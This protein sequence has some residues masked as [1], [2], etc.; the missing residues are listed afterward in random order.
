MSVLFF[1]T[2]LQLL[3]IPLLKKLNGNLKSSSEW[4]TNRS[5]LMVQN[6]GARGG[7]GSGGGTALGMG[8]AG[9]GH[10]MGALGVLAAAS[11][12]NNS[13][14]TE[15]L[16]FGR[17]RPLSHDAKRRKR[18]EDKQRGAWDEVAI[19]WADSYQNI[20]QFHNAGVRAF[21]DRDHFAA[22][23][24]EIVGHRN[25]NSVIGRGGRN[26]ARGAAAVIEGVI[27]DG[28]GSIDRARGALLAAGYTD[29][30]VIGAAIAA[31]KHVDSY[32]ED[33]PFELKQLSMFMAS[34]RNFQDNRTAAN[35][36]E[37]EISALRFRRAHPGGVDL[38]DTPDHLALAQEYWG[39]PT[40]ER[41]KEL[42][43]IADGYHPDGSGSLGVNG[44]GS[45]TWDYEDGS[46][47]SV[48]LTP[49]EA[50]RI[51]TW[52]GNEHAMRTIVSLDDVMGLPAGELHTDQANR[53]IARLRRTGV[54]ATRDDIRAAGLHQ[55][56]WHPAPPRDS[57]L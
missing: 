20:R 30:R 53:A 46:N 49:M 42:R 57:S 24:G 37:V 43:N 8:H 3:F 35:L 26:S 45:I 6:A 9:V 21:R 17:S 32:T 41:W 50:Q 51:T 56:P 2:I 25:R 38:R 47:R 29:E 10:S 11:T 31:R 55:S 39:R 22:N 34:L 28:G 52:V 14:I 33:E 54:R 44:T 5:A 23:V 15:L 48:S 27:E 16:F 19:E 7:S 18:V 13:P 12:L 40:A 4:F 36:A 1:V